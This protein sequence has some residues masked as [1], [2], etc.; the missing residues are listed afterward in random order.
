MEANASDCNDLDLMW[1]ILI[2]YFGVSEETLKVTTMIDGYSSQT[3]HDVLYAV[4]G[5]RLFDFEDPDVLVP[6]EI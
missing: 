2:D 1:T 5:E 4:A 3:L 6:R